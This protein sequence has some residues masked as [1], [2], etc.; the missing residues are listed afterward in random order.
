MLLA[1]EC[2]GTVYASRMYQAQVLQRRQDDTSPAIYM[3]VQV[4]LY[5]CVMLLWNHSSSH[6]ADAWRLGISLPLAMK[7]SR[8]SRMGRFMRLFAGGNVSSSLPA[9][10]A[11]PTR[12]RVLGLLF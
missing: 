6:A 7:S 4:W 11:H 3:R 8:A 5:A 9:A 1:L 10:T 2:G 12:G